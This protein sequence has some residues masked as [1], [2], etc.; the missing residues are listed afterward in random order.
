MKGMNI[1]LQSLDAMREADIQAVDPS[2]L[3]DMRKIQIDTSLPAAERI[4]DY[5]R[6]IGN[7]YCYKYGEY[8]VKVR[9]ADKNET[10][11]DRLES[12]L[13]SLI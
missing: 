3:R 13:R 7:P 1:T 11:N 2:D 8:M 12:Y 9:Y 5:L 10:L 6:Q 4:S